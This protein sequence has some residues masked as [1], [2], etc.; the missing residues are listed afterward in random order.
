MHQSF[1]LLY[2]KLRT[3]TVL[4]LATL[5]AANAFA[6]GPYVA[7]APTGNDNNTGLSSGSLYATIQNAHD[8]A[9]EGDVI[10]VVAGIWP[11]LNT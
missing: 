8:M 1:N 2:S 6:T 5:L 4:C 11:L 3:R 9:N 10:K 7:P